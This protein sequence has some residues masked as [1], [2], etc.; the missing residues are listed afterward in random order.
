MIHLFSDSD[1]LRFIGQVFGHWVSAWGGIALM[2]IAMIEALRDKKVPKRLFFG[3]AIFCLVIA[4]FQAWRDE[5]SSAEWRGYEI[6]RLS[7]DN[8]R[9][10]QEA[11]LRAGVDSNTRTQE[12]IKIRMQLGQLLARNTAIRETCQKDERPKGFSCQDEWIR[13]LDQ[14]RKYLSNNMDPSYSI[15]FRAATGTHMYYK[16][17]PSGKFL[18][19]QDTDAVNVLTFS[20]TSLD[21]FIREFEN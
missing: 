3:A 10:Q 14:T 7:A 16:S 5:Y 18:D 15:R 21:Q 17:L 12:R 6:V 13:W 11:T 2:I 19:D 1:I 20:A 8:T 4:M 9:L